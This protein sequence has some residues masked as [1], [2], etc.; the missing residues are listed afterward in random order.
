[1]NVRP[2]PFPEIVATAQSF[3]AALAEA[4]INEFIFFDQDSSEVTSL[5]DKGPGAIDF[6]E[7]TVFQHSLVA[8]DLLHRLA[9]WIQTLA[10]KGPERSRGF[11]FGGVVSDG[12]GGYLVSITPVD[13]L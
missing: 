10:V 3:L 2:E 12:N 6:R 1:M 11:L 13:L 8:K 5:T 9:C 4:P 7:V